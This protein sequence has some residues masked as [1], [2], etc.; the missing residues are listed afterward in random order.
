MFSQH[1]SHIH[2][3]KSEHPPVHKKVSLSRPRFWRTRLARNAWWLEDG[4][5]KTSSTIKNALQQLRGFARLVVSLTAKA[6]VWSSWG[7]SCQTSQVVCKVPKR[8]GAPCR[9]PY[10]FWQGYEH[11]ACGSFDSHQRSCLLPR[12]VL[13][14]LTSTLTG[15]TKINQLVSTHHKHKELWRG[16]WCAVYVRV[17][18]ACVSCV[19]V[20]GCACGVRVE[21]NLKIREVLRRGKLK[22]EK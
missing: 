19:V 1:Y 12:L 21:K 8:S 20:V 9:S 10:L 3:G 7:T 16:V 11:E 5:A 18:C 14:F 22:F 17:R 6:N 13:H 2:L 15:C 4:N